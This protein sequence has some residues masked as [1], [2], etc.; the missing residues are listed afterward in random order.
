ME[1]S[2]IKYPDDSQVIP[3]QH[4]ANGHFI[5]HDMDDMLRPWDPDEMFGDINEEMA[6]LQQQMHHMHKQMG[7]QPLMAPPPMMMT[8]GFPPPPMPLA[9]PSHPGMPPMMP[10][11]PTDLTPAQ[12]S[13][14][15]AGPVV[16]Q[17]RDGQRYMEVKLEA[18]G[19]GADD[20]QVVTEGDQLLV[21]GRCQSVRRQQSSDSRMAQQF[22]RQFSMPPETRP[23]FLRCR[24]GK[25]GV[26]TIDAPIGK[27]YVPSKKDRR[28]KFAVDCKECK[29]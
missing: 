16:K 4:G 14:L 3:V 28:V 17:G 2:I 22:K 5:N 25:D 23:E 21:H 24:F 1:K 26:L 6:R 8:P 10:L 15:P 27:D 7:M 19:Y 29:D 13:R 9:L 20:I 11:Q 18:G 12:G